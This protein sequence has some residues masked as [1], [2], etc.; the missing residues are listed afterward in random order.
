[1]I[2]DFCVVQE[3]FCINGFISTAF[4]QGFVFAL[5]LVIMFFVLKDI[6][7]MSKSEVKK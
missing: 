2:F 1:M 6:Y 3:W 7:L 4:V 5:I